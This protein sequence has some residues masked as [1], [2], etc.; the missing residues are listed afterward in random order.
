[1]GWCRNE[2]REISFEVYDIVISLGYRQHYSLSWTKIL[3]K[4]R[5]LSSWEY[6]A[7]NIR[8]IKQTFSQ[9]HQPGLSITYILYMC[10]VW[11]PYIAKIKVKYDSLKD[12]LYIC[13]FMFLTMTS[14]NFFIL[15][16]TCNVKQELPIT[17]Y[18][19]LI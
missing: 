17:Q 3:M 8:C 7:K 13:I 11:W 10:I 6:C 2:Q 18:A 12:I 4:S 19:Q 5:I 14:I 16:I 15:L 9:G 1:M